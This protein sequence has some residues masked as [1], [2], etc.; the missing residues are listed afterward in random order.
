MINQKMISLK[1]NIDLLEDLDRCLEPSEKRNRA[2]NKAIAIYIDLIKTDNRINF[3]SQP[4]E[5]DSLMLQFYKR[6][7]SKLPSWRSV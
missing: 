1:V 5:C 4:E 3:E 7:K 6:A 2:I